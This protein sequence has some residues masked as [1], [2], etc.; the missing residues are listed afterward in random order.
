[1]RASFRIS[2]PVLLAAWILAFPGSTHLHSS[3]LRNPSEVIPGGETLVYEVRWDPPAW[4]FFIPTISAGEMTLKFE[5]GVDDRG[6]PIFRITADAVSS[7][8]LPR[9]T[10]ITVKDH[11]E[12]LVT[13]E[14]FCSNQIHQDH[15]GRQAPPRRGADLRPGDSSGPVPGLRRCPKTAQ[16]IEE[17]GIG[18]PSTLRP[19]LPVSHLPHSIARAPGGGKL[20]LAR[21]RQ[22]GGQESRYP[23]GGAGEGGGHCGNLLHHQNRH[24]CRGRALQG[25]RELRA[26][27]HR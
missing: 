9:L 6:R 26:L 4:L 1:M 23:R 3:N 22:R 21:E 19:G 25:G 27:V 11:F 8:V 18:R 15:P 7:G 16:G 13:A 20:S 14:E 12:S 17:R 2:A 24:R 5:R 10:G